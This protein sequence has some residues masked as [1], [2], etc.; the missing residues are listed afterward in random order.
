MTKKS[1]G[2]LAAIIGVLLLLAS[3]TLDHIGLGQNPGFGLLQIAGSVLGL[4]VAVLGTFLWMQPGPE[5]G[6]EA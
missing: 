5:A 2:M 4:V 1:I 6:D 3:V